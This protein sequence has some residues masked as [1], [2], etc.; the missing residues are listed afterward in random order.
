MMILDTEEISRLYVLF[1]DILEEKIVHA[2]KRSIKYAP[3][4]K[5]TIRF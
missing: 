3:L 5:Y 4:N 2:K 1:S